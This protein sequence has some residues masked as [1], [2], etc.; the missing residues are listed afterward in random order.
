MSRELM[1]LLPVCGHQ[2]LW[3]CWLSSHAPVPVR[4]ISMGT[5]LHP[6]SAGMTAGG[7]AVTP[8][9]IVLRSVELNSVHLHLQWWECG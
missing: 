7:W 5:P 4:G 8:Q 1:W 3:R 2:G 6:E 9:S